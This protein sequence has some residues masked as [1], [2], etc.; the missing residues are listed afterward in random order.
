[1][2]FYLREHVKAVAKVPSDVSI[3]GWSCLPCVFQRRD[4]WAKKKLCKNVMLASKMKQRKREKVRAPTPSVQPRI[5]GRQNFQNKKMQTQ[6]NHFD[7]DSA[8]AFARFRKHVAPAL[9]KIS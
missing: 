4:V 7:S 3:G 6:T 9:P 8:V 1:M 5:R 2:P